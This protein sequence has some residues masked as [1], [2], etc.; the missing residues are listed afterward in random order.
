[1]CILSLT[2]YKGESASQF[3]LPGPKGEPGSPGYPGTDPSF[4]YSNKK[5]CVLKTGTITSSS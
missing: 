1:M 3:G 4:S 2:G 5:E